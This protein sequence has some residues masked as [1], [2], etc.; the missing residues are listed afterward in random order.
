MDAYQGYLSEK[1]RDCPELS[2]RW[3]LREIKALGYTGSYTSVT[4]YLRS[5]RPELPRVFEHRFE[6]GPGEQAQV[7][8]AEFSVQFTDEPGV[9]RKVWLFSFVLAH[10]SLVG[11][12][13]RARWS[14]LCVI[15]GKIFS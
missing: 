13:P 9:M 15:S 12:K 6:T 4:D 8:F 3:L 11:L 2:G 14:A 10:R 1:I 7:D 5:I